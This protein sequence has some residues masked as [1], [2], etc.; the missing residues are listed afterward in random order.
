[1]HD[2]GLGP[3]FAVDTHPAD[4]VPPEPWRAMHELVDD[5]AT[6]LDRVHAVRAR[7]ASGRPPEAVPLR[8]AASVAHLGLVAR[9]VSPA[10][11]VAVRR[12]AV[13]NI[14]LRRTWW[15]PVLGGPFPLS[16]TDTP[17]PGKENF[18]SQVLDGPIRTLGEALAALSVSPRILWGNVASA[19]H[20]A[21][22]MITAERPTLA[23]ETR[24]FVARLLTEPPLAGTG[25]TT[26]GRFR[27]RSC[28]LIYRAAPDGKGP[29]CGDCVLAGR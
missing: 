25:T 1:V 22:S 20:G 24:T 28:C 6:L 9:L 7:L 26:G 23:N 29:V 17:C 8:V 12:H 13:L 27:R 10:L 2:A 16:V 3:F 18:T 14:D 15:Q 19:L 21:A 4:A 5:P 11:D